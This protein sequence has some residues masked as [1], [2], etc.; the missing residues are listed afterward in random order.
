MF[1]VLCWIVLVLAVLT[2][3]AG[4]ARADDEV[5]LS[6][7]GHTWTADLNRPLFDP[8]M[9]WIP[10]DVETRSFWVRND[11]PAKASMKI[12]VRT[13]DP[14]ALFAQD[15]ILIDAR[16]RGGRWAPLSHG[17]GTRALTDRTLAK[18]GRVRVDLR[19]TFVPEATNRT[20]L[21]AAS[22]STSSSGSPKRG[23]ATSPATTT[24]ATTAPTAACRTPALR[25][26]R[27]SCGWPAC[28]SAAASSS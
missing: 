19:V 22:R 5:G 9:R 21:S 18:G 13:T 7:D 3:G 24:P 15:D 25:W 23:A 8:A 16:V 27:G 20:E 17:R 2:A 4:A 11:G 6:L 26:S 10:G 28:C 12:G 14:D 1:R